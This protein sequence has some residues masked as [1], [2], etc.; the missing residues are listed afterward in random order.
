[1]PF[2]S[3]ADLSADLR[4]TERAFR[5]SPVFLL[6]ATVS[7]ALGIGANTAIFT[8]LDDVLWKFAPGGRPALSGALH[9]LAPES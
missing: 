2:P 5:R 8:A 6:T 7:L 9:H 1:M 4:Y 3:F